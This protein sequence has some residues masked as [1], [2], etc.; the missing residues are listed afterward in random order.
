VLERESGMSKANN[1]YDTVVP[2]P[3]KKEI[4]TTYRKHNI[5]RNKEGSVRK[6]NGKVYID[7][8]Y[9][10]ERVRECSGNIW[11]D[12]NAKT[13]RQQLD[14]IIVA[15]Q[16]GK[17]RF[18]EVFPKSKKLDY[19]AGKEQ[20]V[21]SFQIPPD[22]VNFREYAKAWYTLAEGSNRLSGRTLHEYGGYLDKYLIPFFGKMSMC[23]ITP[24]TLEQFISW[25]RKRK[26]RKKSVKNSSINKYLVLLKQI[27]THSTVDYG[28]INR[29]SPFQGF[30]MLPETDPIENI[31]P[32]SIDEQNGLKNVFSCHWKPYFDFAFALGLRPGEQIA[33]K[34]DDIDW[35]K[36]LL[37]VKRSITTDKNGHRIEGPTKNKYSRRTIKLNDI[38]FESLQRQKVFSDKFDCE[39]FFCTELGTP[40]YL[41]NLRRDIWLPASKKAQLE[42]RALKQ[43]RHTFATIALSCGEN[44]LWIARVMGHKNTEMIIKHYTRYVENVT[45]TNDG[46]AMNNLYKNSM[47]NKEE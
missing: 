31:L 18:A 22:K 17:F 27:C 35:D 10:E 34:E 11:N 33:L 24:H 41:S 13:A 19:F 29:Y 6:I 38:M 32:F 8:I 7:F 25:A 3:Q 45:Q 44:P 47:S 26:L 21:Y 39:Y 5:N 28:W 42:I 37:Q 40:I 43:T 36:R 12:K 20:Q 23:G 4:K 15:I 16:T 2:F 9:L 14:R 1:A 30:R 46:N